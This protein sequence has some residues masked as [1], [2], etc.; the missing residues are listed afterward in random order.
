MQTQMIPVESSMFSAIGYDPERQELLTQYKTGTLGGY[1][2]V[3]KEEFEALFAADSVGKAFNT[4]IRPSKKFRKV[5]P[6]A[7]EA[8][9]RPELVEPIDL[10]PVTIEPKLRIVEAAPATPPA[11]AEVQQ[12]TN[13]IAIRATSFEVLTHASHIEAQQIVV[14]I[15]SMRKQVAEFF[16]PM[17]KAAHNAHKA[18][19]DREN[20]TL[21]PLQEAQK[22]LGARIV[23]FEQRVREEAKAEEDRLRREA[24]AEE[25]RRARDE[26]ERLAI[27]DAIV[28]EEV[29]DLAGA[30]AVLANPAPVLPRYVPPPVVHTGLNRVSGV[31]T[32]TTWKARVT[33]PNLIP[34]EYMMP[35]ES[36]LGR[37]A[38]AL[39]HKARV[40]GVEFYAD[41]TVSGRCSA[42]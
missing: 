7:N 42:C 15:A 12:Q 9:S 40:P 36:A 32:R 13:D 21:K 31:A 2:P 5:E 26:S 18:V 23:A 10:P 14:D 24:Q 41:T 39:K 22:A 29:G 4:Q 27:E 1:T 19:C 16:A 25:D 6:V 38:N 28:L 11:E 34:R 35:D 33:N 20:E 17:K 30:A 8:A 37:L 3:T